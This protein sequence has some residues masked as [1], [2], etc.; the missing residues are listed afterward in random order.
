MCR[1]LCFSDVSSTR[2]AYP[3]FVLAFTLT[4]GS[5]ACEM[6]PF[7]HRN[8]LVSGMKAI[9]RRLTSLKTKGKRKQNERVPRCGICGA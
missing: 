9:K 7:V 5:M 3:S 8:A 6:A 1:V 2:N 4:A